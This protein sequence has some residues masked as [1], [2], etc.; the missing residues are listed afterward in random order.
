M[1][2]PVPVESPPSVHGQ[3]MAA[4]FKP[5]E[6]RRMTEDKSS[7][8]MNIIDKRSTNLTGSVEAMEIDKNQFNISHEVPLNLK[9]TASFIRLLIALNRKDWNAALKIVGTGVWTWTRLAGEYVSVNR[10]MPSTLEHFSAGLFVQHLTSS[11][12][13]GHKLLW[14]GMVTGTGQPGGFAGR[15]SPGTGVEPSRQAS[16]G[17]IRS[18]RTTRRQPVD[19]RGGVRVFRVRVHAN[20]SSDPA[21][22]HA[23][24]IY[25][26]LSQCNGGE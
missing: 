24:A 26:G 2:A 4:W 13:K 21:T 16:A 9:Q 15:V 14:I 8:R 12:S 19:P 11:G 23:V 17:L 22:G 10:Q 25:A 5:M 18:I 6:K 1:Y 7:N 3:F 20:S